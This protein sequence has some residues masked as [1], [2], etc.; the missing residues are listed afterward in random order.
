MGSATLGYPACSQRPMC[1]AV[2]A[3]ATRDEALALRLTG[4]DK[5]LPRQLDAGFDRFRPTAAEKGIG[6]A[7]RFIAAELVG[8]RL[9][10]LRGKEAG[11]GIGELRGLPGYRLDNAWML[12]SETGN[13]SAARSIENP[14]AALGNQPHA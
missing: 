14:T 6:E 1:F 12:M 8:Q 4:L 3:V 5:I 2:V 11:M 9:C 10:R 7:A 13:S